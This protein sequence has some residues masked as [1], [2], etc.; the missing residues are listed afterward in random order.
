MPRDAEVA[1]TFHRPSSVS[2]RSRPISAKKPKPATR[3]AK[4][5]DALK[6]PIVY[7]NGEP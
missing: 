1:A 3:P 2:G 7:E 5:A 4:V 6:R